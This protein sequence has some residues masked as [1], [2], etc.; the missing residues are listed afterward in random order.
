MYFSEC[1]GNVCL[2]DRKGVETPCPIPRP[3]QRVGNCYHIYFLVVCA[4]HLANYWSFLFAFHHLP[5]TRFV[6]LSV[7]QHSVGTIFLPVR[8][9]VV[10]ATLAKR[11]ACVLKW[12]AESE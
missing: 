3:P 7:V 12:K 11:L 2:G 1:I 6:T 10:N 9:V 4:I 5:L 8:G